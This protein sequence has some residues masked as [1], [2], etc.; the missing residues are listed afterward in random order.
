M[1]MVDTIRRALR[2]YRAEFGLSRLAVLAEF[3]LIGAAMLFV[4]SG[5]WAFAVMTP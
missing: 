4:A 1:S 3:A 5:G 2:E